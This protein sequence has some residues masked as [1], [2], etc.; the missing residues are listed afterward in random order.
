MALARQSAVLLAEAAGDERLCAAL[1]EIHT[2]TTR[3]LENE[4]K[5]N[6]KVKELEVLIRHG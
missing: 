1:Q 4:E 6:A 2:L 5:N 3:L